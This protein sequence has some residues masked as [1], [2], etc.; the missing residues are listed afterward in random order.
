MDQQEQQLTP[1]Q[2]MQQIYAQ[3]HRTSLMQQIADQS[4]RIADLEANLAVLQHQIELLD[5]AAK[6]QTN[7]PIGDGDSVPGDKPLEGD[8]ETADKKH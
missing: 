4:Q 1:E 8:L 5:K 3:R 6:A 7:L 2:Q